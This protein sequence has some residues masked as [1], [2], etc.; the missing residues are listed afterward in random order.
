L[1]NSCLKYING[2][3]DVIGDRLEYAPVNEAKTYRQVLLI[4]S[5]AVPIL[6]GLEKAPAVDHQS[7]YAEETAD[8]DGQRD[9]RKPSR[10]KNRHILYNLSFIITRVPRL[11]ETDCRALLKVETA[12]DNGLRQFKEYRFILLPNQRHCVGG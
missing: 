5:A 3:V 1:H 2:P 12:I 8:G 4:I 10:D 11:T 9:L 7:F 6:T